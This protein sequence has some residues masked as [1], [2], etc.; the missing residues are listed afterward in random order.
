[1]SRIAY[2]SH[3]TLSRLG[4]I[5]RCNKTVRRGKSFMFITHRQLHPLLRDL[6]PLYPTSTHLH[7]RCFACERPLDLFQ[8]PVDRSHPQDL[9]S[10]CI[11]YRKAL[12]ISS[13]LK[14]KHSNQDPSI[15]PSLWR[16][17]FIPLYVNMTN[18]YTEGTR[19]KFRI[20]KRLSIRICGAEFSFQE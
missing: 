17:S 1:M 16:I 8:L 18:S 9:C 15:Y 5:F 20:S 4:S 11:L 12:P 2:P 3:V 19:S 6:D 7:K 14:K 13:Y 10:L